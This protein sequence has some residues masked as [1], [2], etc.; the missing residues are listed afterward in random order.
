MNRTIVER[1]KCM[2]KLAKLPKPFWS[3]AILTACYL[4]NRS[5]SVPLGFEISKRIWIEKAVSYPIKV[6][7][8]RLLSI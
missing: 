6:L 3:G 4:I 8:A 1:M 7:G 2:L 5:L